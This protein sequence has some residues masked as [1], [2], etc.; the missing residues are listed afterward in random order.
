M[1]LPGLAGCD[2][3]LT[4]GGDGADE[5]EGGGS[6]LKRTADL[7]V[8]LTQ[9]VDR[10]TVVQLNYSASRADGY[11]NDP[12]KFVSVVESAAGTAPGEPLRQLYEGR[13]DARLK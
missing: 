12:Y 7:L 5:D 6:E 9:I 11:L 2:P 1:A 4:S 13:P 10:S 3:S 8:G